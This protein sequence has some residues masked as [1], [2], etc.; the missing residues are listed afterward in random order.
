MCV[1]VSKIMMYY[2]S[3][4]YILIITNHLLNFY[5]IY[6]RPNKFVKEREPNE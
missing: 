2:M 1:Y 6:F 4:Y 5:L 3:E